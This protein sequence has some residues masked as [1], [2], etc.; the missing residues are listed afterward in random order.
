[1]ADDDTGGTPAGSGADEGASPA[2]QLDPAAT[3]SPTQK[4]I[5]ELTRKRHDADREAAYW[6]GKAEAG[7]AQPS[8]DAA[9]K[10]V[11]AD[12]LKPDDFDSDSEYVKAYA[13]A[14]KA[15]IVAE[16]A[17]SERVRK[18]AAS[19]AEI[20]KSYAEGRKAH[21][22]FDS[23]ALSQSLPVTQVMFDASIGKNLHEVLYHLGENPDEAARISVLAP[24]QQIKEIGKIEAKLAALPVKTTKAPN[25]PTTVGGGGSPPPAD[26]TGMTRQERFAKWEKERRKRMTGV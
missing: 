24:T 20:G 26:E 1:M 18:A 9:P 14:T 13:K 2:S 22:D 7:T 12:D 19:Q 23:V 11:K 21:E 4:R 8:P 25:P 5:N 6:K 3:E 16:N 15:E 17:E 10:V